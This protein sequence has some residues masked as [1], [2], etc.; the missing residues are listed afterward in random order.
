MIHSIQPLP[1]LQEE[2]PFS[3]SEEFLA[4]VEMDYK[5]ANNN[6]FSNL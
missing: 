6:Y 5:E 1:I 3:V 4:T 2:F